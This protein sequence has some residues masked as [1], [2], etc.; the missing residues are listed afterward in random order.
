MILSVGTTETLTSEYTLAQQQPSRI[1]LHN[2]QGETLLR[3]GDIFC[4]P[5]T[6]HASRPGE[7]DLNLFFVYSEVAIS[8]SLVIITGLANLILI[9]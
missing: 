1:I 2:E 3:P 8:P 9:I 5:L 6:L 4:L 7:R